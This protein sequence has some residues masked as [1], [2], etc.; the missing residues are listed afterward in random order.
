MNEPVERTCTELRPGEA[1]GPDRDSKPLSAYRSAQAYV[2]LGDPGSG[3]TTAFAA[4]SEELGDEALFI[5]ARNFLVHEPVPDEWRE[6]TLFIDGLDEV[7]AGAQ[8]V[9]TRFDEIRRRLIRLDKPRFRISC[10]ESDWLGE[11][12]RQHLEI[13]SRDSTVTALRL[14]ALTQPDIKIILRVHLGVS[15]PGVFINQAHEHGVGGL[16]ANPQALGLLAKA[17]MHEGDWPNSRIETFELACDQMAREHNHEHSVAN[18]PGVPVQSLIDSAGRLCAIQLISDRIGYS[19]DR[20][21]PDEDYPPFQECGQECLEGLRAALSSK[22]FKADAESGCRFSPVHRQIA[23]F[24]GGKH[25]ARLIEDGLPAQRVVALMAGGDGIVVTALRGLASWLATHSEQAR[26]TLIS[27]DAVGVG[28]YGDIHVFSLDEKRMLLT[29]LASQPKSLRRAWTNVN[30]FV[31]LAVAGTEPQ[32]RQILASTDRSPSQEARVEFILLVLGRGQ[33]LPG[34]ETQMLE[35]VRDDSWSQ[36]MRELALDAFIRY[37][38]DSSEPARE[39]EELLAD[40]KANG[41]SASNRNLCGTMLGALYPRVVPPRQVWDYLTERAGKGV[42]GGRYDQFWS[43]QLVAQSSENDI[44][45]LLDSL[46]SQTSRLNPVFEHLRLGKLPLALLERGLH[47][48]GDNVAAERVYEWLGAGGVGFDGFAGYPPSSLVRIRTW[49]EHRPDFQ[50]QVVSMGLAACPDDDRVSFHDFRN[51]KRLFGA[52][53]PADFDLWCL[54]QAVN[55]AVTRPQVA[56]YLFLEAYRAF[57]TLDGGKGLSM[58]VLQEHA[59]RDEQLENLLADLESPPPASQDEM[60]WQRQQR[61]YIE[62]QEQ[63]KREWLD[64]IRSNRSALLENRAGPALLYQLALAYFGESPYDEGDGHGRAAVERVLGDYDTFNAAMKG[65]CSVIDRDDLP[66]LRKIVRLAKNQQKPYLSLPLLAALEEAESSKPGVLRSV[67]ESRVRIFVACYYHWA[68]DLPGSRGKRPSWYQRLLESRPELVA[69]VAVQCATAALR[70]RR[71]VSER[72]WDVT[73]DEVNRGVARQAILDLLGLFPTRSNARQ[74]ETLDQLLWTGFQFGAEANLLHLAN[75]KLQNVSMDVGQQVRWLGLGLICAP[76]KYRDRITGIVDGKERWIR[77]LAR[78]YVR[79]AGPWIS[80]E[81]PWRFRYEDLD[82]STLETVI[83]HLGT[84]F[85]PA[86][87]RGFGYITDEYFAPQFLDHLIRSLASNPD[88][89]ATVALESLLGNTKLVRWY[90]DLSRARDTQRTVRRDTEYRHP[91]LTEAVMTLRDGPPANPGDL[92]ALTVD[93][94]GRLAVRI[95]TS[96]SNEWSH[97]WNEGKHGKPGQPK[98][99]NS[100]RDALLPALKSLLP[101][102]VDAQPERQHVNSTR[103]D[104]EISAQGFHLPVEVKRNSDRQ[105]WSASHDQLI[106]KYTVDPETDGYG[107]YLVFWF[108]WDNQKARADGVQPKSPKELQDRLEESLTV[109]EARKIS[110]CVVDVTAPNADPVHETIGRH[111]TG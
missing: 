29:E 20:N 43:K 50:K 8:D 61:Q 16:L 81:H 94:L 91:T 52:K 14:D 44:L 96:N 79:G 6:R 1:D 36:Q 54:K 48:H 45:G 72:F 87:L 106:A 111:G 84:Y 80:G 107:I 35:I 92:A 4:E 70:S 2:L 78:F 40:F 27:N 41:I 55:L 76:E 74:L 33:R 21:S 57:K 11:N 12:D 39:L 13:V 46:A 86:E 30:A 3:K 89:C 15:D 18:G 58:K 99:E 77:H 109:D 26:S 42:G 85:A 73:E 7:R 25:L 17:V 10:R 59:G 23:E 68:P 102:L 56:R 103:A 110:I 65:L 88:K 60:E 64:W 104:I 5:T 82:S 101:A 66:S 108:G 62:T 22:L 95:R 51:R 100:C 32:I 34:L 97:Y 105:L 19:L 24:L 83:R 31:P 75:R 90:E 47:L 93:V 9:R 53:L 28:M 49:L 37:Q 67:E 71:P 63:Q 38:Q 98:T 69:E